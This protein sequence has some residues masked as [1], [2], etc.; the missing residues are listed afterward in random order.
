MPRENSGL[1]SVD[2]VAVANEANL[3]EGQAI[4]DGA[5]VN[6]TRCSV[7]V[8]SELLVQGRVYWAQFMGTSG[9]SDQETDL[10][11]CEQL[12]CMVLQIY[13]RIS[14]KTH[15]CMLSSIEHKYATHHQHR[16]TTTPSAQK[17]P[18]MTGQ[19]SNTWCNLSLYKAELATVVMVS[20]EISVCLQHASMAIR[21][22]NKG[23][24]TLK[25][26]TAP[27]PGVHKFHEF[28]L[29]VVLKALY[30]IQWH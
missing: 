21:C 16:L 1:M 8:S 29:R 10:S 26:A 24:Y 28:V 9:L 30:I 2:E 4:F 13:N 22:G 19:L 20:I 18:D 7:G 3:E 12:R 23:L 25:P 27:S 15:G 11:S 17:D 14:M 5:K 6:W